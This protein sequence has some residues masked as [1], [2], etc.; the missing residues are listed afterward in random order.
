[1]YYKTLRVSNLA[2]LVCCVFTIFIHAEVR[3]PAIV[4]SN[5]VLQRNTTI[6]LWG[7]ADANEHI[8]ITTSW[9]SDDLKVVANANGDWFI[10][11]L[12]TGSKTTQTITI[13]SKNSNIKLHNIIFGEVW[14]C[15]GQSNMYQPMKG[16]NGQPT[17]DGP[18][19]AA[20]ANNPNLRLFTVEKTASKLPLNDTKDYNDWQQATP[21]SVLNFSAVAYFFGQQLQEILDVPVGLIHTS[22]GGSK[23]QAWI[24]NDMLSKYET[25]DINNRDISKGAQGI[26]TVLFNAMIN[27][28][29]NYTIKGALWYQGESN[30]NEPK[31]YEK[32]FPAM[33]EDWRNQWNIGDFP[34]YFVQ[35]APYIYTGN[36]SFNTYKNTAFIRESQLNCVNLIPNSG[37]AITMDVGSEHFIHP[38]HK[39]EVANRLLFNALH[40]TYGYK[41]IEYA[42]PIF[43]TQEA[44]DGGLL[45]RFKHAK[46]GLFTYDTLKGFEIAGEDKIFYPAEAVIT[47]R[48]YIFVKNSNVQNPVAVRYAWKN[49]IQGTLFSTSLLPVSSFRTDT[50]D[51]TTRVKN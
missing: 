5:M 15:S 16:Y 27:P 50:W 14:L 48:K 31:H 11:A 32:V 33:V 30:R 38:P 36:T 49:W 7:W 9:L 51:D 42:T 20:K 12:T 28:I 34:F 45:L 46:Q 19:A 41:S 6:K 26:S 25:V 17:F 37:I 40:Q 18:M 2:T 21:K 4:S 8:T 44:K 22:W 23:V 13:K 43:D 47:N 3:L 39:K 35:I 24:S 10:N 29:T 1:M